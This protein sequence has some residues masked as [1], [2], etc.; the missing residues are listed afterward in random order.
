MA[1]LENA[2]FSSQSTVSAS[3]AIDENDS[4]ALL[5]VDAD[6]ASRTLT[7]PNG[8]PEGFG[9]YVR[10]EAGSNDITLSPA[11]NSA[12]A[13]AVGGIRSAQGNKIG[14]TVG[15]ALTF[16]WRTEIT[17]EWAATGNLIS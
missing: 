10:R 7:L 15:G 12:S 9:F 11:T 2:S 1:Y 13:Y 5:N 6:A 8:L 16:V 17:N 14:S 3:R 4:L